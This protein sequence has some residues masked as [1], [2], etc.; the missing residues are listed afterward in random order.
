MYIDINILYVF[1]YLFILNVNIIYILLQ[2]ISKP[3]YSQMEF[4]FWKQ[5]NNCRL[6]GL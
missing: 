4:F 1:T 5:K 2:G 6:T 3:I